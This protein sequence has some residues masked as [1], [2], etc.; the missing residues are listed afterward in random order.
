[1]FYPYFPFQQFLCLKQTHIVHLSY[2]YSRSPLH[3]HYQCSSSSSSHRYHTFNF[4]SGWG[5]RPDPSACNTNALISLLSLLLLLSMLFVLVLV[6]VLVLRM[7]VSSH[8]YPHRN[9]N[10]ILYIYYYGMR[11][12]VS[13]LKDKRARKTLCY[14]RFLLC[15]SYSCYFSVER[16]EIL[17]H[18]AIYYYFNVQTTSRN[19]SQALLSCLFQR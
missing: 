5:P 12:L 7:A 2:N 6:R 19:T 15:K 14:I 9:T 4:L 16:Q 3:Y 13:T 11:I 1:M 18:I 8:Y 10:V 17:Q